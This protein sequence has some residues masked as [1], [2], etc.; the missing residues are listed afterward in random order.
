MAAERSSESYFDEIEL[1]LH[2][3]FEADAADYVEILRTR[4][5]KLVE[6]RRYWVLRAG[7]FERLCDRMKSGRSEKVAPSEEGAG[8]S[9]NLG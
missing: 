3:H 6:D 4:W 5:K 2:R 9:G 7:R 1:A 8:D